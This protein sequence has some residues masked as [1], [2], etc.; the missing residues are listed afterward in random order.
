LVKVLSSGRTKE[1]PEKWRKHIF[2]AETISSYPIQSGLFASILFTV[3][4]KMLLENGVKNKMPLENG[5]ST[6][7]PRGILF[8][9]FVTEMI[10]RVVAKKAALPQR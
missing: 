6:Y 8:Y 5:A 2:F 3:L 9:S 7:F 1:A 4:I 10:C